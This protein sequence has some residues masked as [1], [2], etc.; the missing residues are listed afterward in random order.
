[1]KSHQQAIERLMLS[2]DRE[3]LIEEVT[4]RVLARLSVS[5][6]VTKVTQEI[7]ELKK[8]LESVF[9]ILKKGGR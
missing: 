1:M 8:Q 3:A 4:K 6:D 7:E 9:S 2:R 5:L